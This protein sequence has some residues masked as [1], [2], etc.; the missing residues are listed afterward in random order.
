MLFRPVLEIPGTNIHIPGKP[1]RKKCP[2]CKRDYNK[3]KPKADG[4]KITLHCPH[5][6]HRIRTENKSA[7]KKDKKKQKDKKK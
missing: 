3:E 5:C 4:N 2:H 6:N 7:K 1:G